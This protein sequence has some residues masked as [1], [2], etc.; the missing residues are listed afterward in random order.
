MPGILHRGHHVAFLVGDDSAEHRAVVYDPA[1]FRGI[2]LW[3]IPSVQGLVRIRD[4]DRVRNR[5]HGRRRIAGDH[6]RRHVLLDEVGNRVGCIGTDLFGKREV[7]DRLE[8]IRE[9]TVARW[10]RC[11]GCSHE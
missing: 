8:P 3:K 11:V 2:G 4:T 1:E 10:Q 5:T 9:H 6:L 7:A